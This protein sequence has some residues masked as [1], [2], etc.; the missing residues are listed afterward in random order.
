MA[1]VGARFKS[2]EQVGHH[3]G[4]RRSVSGRSARR[5]VGAWLDCFCL[6]MISSNKLEPMFLFT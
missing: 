2:I 3:L 1:N 6:V 5:R 4:F